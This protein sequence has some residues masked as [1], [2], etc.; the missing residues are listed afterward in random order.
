MTATRFSLLCGATLAAAAAYVPMPAQ[1]ATNATFQVA[2]TIQRGCQ[3]D[4][5]GS[6][7][8]AGTVGV[9]NFGQD[10]TLST[11]TRTAD[12]GANQSV[13]LRCTPGVSV[14]MRIDGGL[15]AAAGVRNLQ[16][17]SATANRL[18]Y[19]LYRD[20]TFSQPIG[21]G[22]A[23]PIV[24]TAANMNNVVLPIY[25]RLTLP[26]NRPAGTYTDTLLITLDW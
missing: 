8:D 15:N 14:L 13:T 17:G 9:L 6:G 10:S 25:G 22:Q 7:G 3:V 19:Q 1:A 11:S 5:V 4:G 21:I 16:L 2:A 12:A 24:V 20:S 18:A 23:Q 26:G